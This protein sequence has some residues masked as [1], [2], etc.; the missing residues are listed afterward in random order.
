MGLHDVDKNNNDRSS[1]AVNAHDDQ[2]IHQRMAHGT[3][4]VNYQTD[5]TNPDLIAGIYSGTFVI[6]RIM[7]KTVPTS[8]FSSDATNWKVQEFT[9]VVPHGLT[10]IPV[11]VGSLATAATGTTNYSF[12]VTIPDNFMNVGTG[13]STATPYFIQYEAYADGTNVTFRVRVLLS[14]NFTYIGFDV[15]FRVYLLVQKATS[16]LT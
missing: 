14:P 10:D 8:T 16:A 5:A 11:I 12:F 7:E 4:S 15:F 6:A 1:P 13:G 2:N 3:N 9:Q